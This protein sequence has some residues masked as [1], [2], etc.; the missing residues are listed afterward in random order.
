MDAKWIRRCL[1]WTVILLVVGAFLVPLTAYAEPASVKISVHKIRGADLL[2]RV[3]GIFRV[4]L[5][6][7]DNVR[8]VTF[9]LDGRPIA[10]VTSYPFAFQLD[11]QDFPKGAHQ[12][13]AVAHLANGSVATSNTVTLEFRSHRWNLAVRQSMFL[14]A[15]LLLVL[16]VIG[17]LGLRKLLHIQPRLILL[18]R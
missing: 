14:Y 3:A 1:L 11:T 8:A 5:Q 4:A 6:G 13:E 15:A 17:A 2:G 12:L 10:Y 18:D 16:G 9:Y 7:P